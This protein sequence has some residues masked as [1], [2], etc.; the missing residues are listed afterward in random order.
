MGLLE[1]FMFQK[2]NLKFIFY[3]I[4]NIIYN[5]VLNKLYIKYKID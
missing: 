2:D 5:N 4:F 3:F 1:L